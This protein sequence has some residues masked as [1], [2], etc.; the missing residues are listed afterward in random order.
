MHNTELW[1]LALI[2]TGGLLLLWKHKREYVRTNRY[3]VQEFGGFWHKIRSEAFDNAL[4]GLGYGSGLAGTLLFVF[5]D[6]SAASWVALLGLI[7]AIKAFS[8]QRHNS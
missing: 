8:S 3:G 1:T 6:S 4:A 2:I 7:F 5:T